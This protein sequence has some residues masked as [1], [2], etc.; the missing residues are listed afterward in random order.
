M[1]FVGPKLF[2]KKPRI[3]K[4]PGYQEMT[5]TVMKYVEADNTDV[6]LYRVRVYDANGQLVRTYM[7]DTMGVPFKDLS[8]VADDME[9]LRILQSQNEKKG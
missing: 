8:D 2:G 3:D 1:P 7:Q 5:P 4:K 6:R 9:Y